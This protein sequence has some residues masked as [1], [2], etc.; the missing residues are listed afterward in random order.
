MSAN[1]CIIIEEKNASN[2]LLY[3]QQCL[4]L[5]DLLK[6]YSYKKFLS[7]S[8]YWSPKMWLLTT[9]QIPQ[10]ITYISNS[11]NSV[12]WNIIEIIHHPFTPLNKIQQP[13]IKIFGICN[14][15]KSQ[16]VNKIYIAAGCWYI[17]YWF[18]IISQYIMS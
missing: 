13:T 17:K 8:K 1:S 4:K 2:I 10:L 12:T 18:S 3:F 7:M 15:I 5:Y 14:P 11:N 6:S 9:F 16:L